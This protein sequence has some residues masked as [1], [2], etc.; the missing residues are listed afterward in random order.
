MAASAFPSPRAV[1]AAIAGINI[2]P[3]VDVMLVLLV[4]FMVTMPIRSEVLALDIPQ[5][6]PP[7]PP[8]PRPE[9]V[10]LDVLADG[11]VMLDGVRL[12][13][14][15]LPA[16]LRAQHSQALTATVSLHSSEAAEYRVFAL[17]LA[18]ARA[19]GY[20]EIAIRR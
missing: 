8:T 19:A 14:A 12:E 4:I 16:E 17:A 2:T 18:A 11:G 5:V 3:L 1:P 9:P 10:R 7:Q 6:G 13:L 15:V 20:R